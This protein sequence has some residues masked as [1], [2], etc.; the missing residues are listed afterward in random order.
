M[1]TT[2]FIIS[3]LCF[4]ISNG[5]DTEIS[6]IK[7]KEAFTP[8]H[9]MVYSYFIRHETMFLQKA[10]PIISGISIFILMPTSIS[11]AFHI[12]WFLAFLI[13]IF[14]KVIQGIFSGIMITPVLLFARGDFFSSIIVTFIIGIIT[15]VMGIIIR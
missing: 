5:I 7:D 1:A 10:I 12:N 6:R 11:L 3:A 8:L 15:M 14:L 9:R 2:L 4:F 13:A